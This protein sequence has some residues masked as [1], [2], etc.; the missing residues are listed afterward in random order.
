[1]QTTIVIVTSGIESSL[2]LLRGGMIYKNIK[3][4]Q[5]NYQIIIVENSNNINFK[6]KVEKS[7]RNIKC[8]LTG[9][10][11]GYARANNIGLRKVKTKF[12]LVVNPDVIIS[13]KQVKQIENLA[14][15][16]IK[17]SVLTP[18]SNGLLETITN[19]SDKLS[20]INKKNLKSLQND[21]LTKNFFE[22][23]FVPGYC[24]FFNMKDVK[25][26]NFFDENIF[27]YFEDLDI[28]KRLKDLKKKFFL[29]SKIK[30]HHLYGGFHEKKTHYGKRHILKKKSFRKW[31]LR[32]TDRNWHL[33]WSSF[34]YHRKHYGFVKSFKVHF[35]KLLRFFFLK[36]F[37]FLMNNK[38]L[39]HLFKARFKGLLYQILNKSAFSG[40]RIN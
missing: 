7:H 10:N 5:N 21:I 35:S 13:S 19:N 28:C 8:Y 33:Y 20:N 22:I 11:L 9:S 1:M 36:N 26:I 37:Y 6:R 25:K 2:I 15:K 17:F 3:D 4:L 30:I 18:N 34:Y 24:M 38:N 12:A 31:Q 40:P 27:L 14:K 32:W 23:N 39:H 16:I 29:L